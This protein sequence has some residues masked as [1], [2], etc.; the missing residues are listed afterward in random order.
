MK[1]I[2]GLWRLPLI[3][4]NENGVPK[5]NIF[6]ESGMIGVVEGGKVNYLLKDHLGSTRVVADEYGE[7]RGEF[8]YSDFGETTEAGEVGNIKYRYTG[9]E[10]DEEVGEYNYLAREYDP[11]TG[12]FNSPDP[13]KQ[14]FSPYVYVGNNPINFVDPDGKVY[15]LS[16]DKYSSLKVDKAIKRWDPGSQTYLDSINPNN[17]IKSEMSILRYREL[18]K[19]EQARVLKDLSKWKDYFLENRDKIDAHA[20]SWYT[21]HSLTEGYII[22]NDDNFLFFEEFIA[23]DENGELLGVGVLGGSRDYELHLNLRDPRA[24]VNRESRPAGVVGNVGTQI[25]NEMINYSFSNGASEV[26]STPISP[27]AKASLEE[28]GFVER[29]I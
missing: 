9:Q 29:F 8:S 22:H 17:G 18:G 27:R 21:I 23:R 28:I 13:A 15:V 16:E 4:V 7:K 20:S 6:D 26:T 1:Y 10:W 19:E 5:I 14:G 3:E 12:R 25:R 2:H 24:L 11:A